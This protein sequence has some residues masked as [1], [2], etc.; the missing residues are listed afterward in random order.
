M[1]DYILE[2]FLSDLEAVNSSKGAGW[3]PMAGKYSSCDIKNYSGC[4]LGSDKPS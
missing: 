4:L 3:N 2:S 1:S